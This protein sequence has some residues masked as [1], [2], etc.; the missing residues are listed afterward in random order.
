MHL[1]YLIFDILSCDVWRVGRD[2][3][4]FMY[5]V[6]LCSMYVLYSIR[7]GRGGNKKEQ[8]LYL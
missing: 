6:F 5:F 4:Y 1:F 2:G 3:F 8:V 7:K